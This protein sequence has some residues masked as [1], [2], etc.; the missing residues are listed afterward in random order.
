[1]L[2]K[3]LPSV[4]RYT[5]GEGIEVVVADNGSTDLSLQVLAEEFAGVRVIRLDSNYGFAE[6]YNRAL[7]Q[8]ESAYTVLLNTDVEV[9]EGWLDKLLTYM[10]A[11][12]EV[13]ATQPKVLS[14]LSHEEQK[15]GKRQ[16]CQFEHAGAAGG[17]ID[18][19]GYPYC[20]GRVLSQVEE[21]RGQYDTPIDIF[22]ATGACLCIRTEVYKQVGGLDNEFFAHM[23]E[24]D[25][26]WRL[27][28]RGYR[29]VCVPQSLVYHLGGGSLSY[30]N[31]RKTMLNF[32]N[33]LLM[34]YKNLPQNRLW[35]VMTMRLLLD[36]AAW[37]MYLLTGH[38]G[39]AKAV[40]QAYKE[41]IAMRKGMKDKRI[42]NLHKAVV[43]YP[44]LIGG[45][46]LLH[47]TLPLTGV[48]RE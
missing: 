1:M 24:I 44:S 40:C 33:N 26:C 30:D 18:R 36:T 2:R 35:R 21:D 20:R 42:D 19:W 11:H 17:F 4:V 43:P 10:D 34:L 7:E 3:Y 27:N 41:Y 13:A 22:W 45:C 32:R 39:N 48:E 15:Q 47:K 9:T 38:A 14:W 16:Y 8:I 31:P 23:E 28:C 5:R 25:L 6:G 37:M 12:T 46:I 29:L